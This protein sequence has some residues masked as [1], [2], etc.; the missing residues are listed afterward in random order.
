MESKEKGKGLSRR[1]FLKGVPIGVVG[2]VGLGLLSRRLWPSSA[3][4]TRD[5]GLSEDSI[6][7]PAK[8]RDQTA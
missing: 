5:A 6:F 7:N 4:R 8:D 3:R 1:G 2:A